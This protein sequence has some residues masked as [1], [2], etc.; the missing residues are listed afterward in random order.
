VHYLKSRSQKDEKILQLNW[1]D[2]LEL[3]LR[4]KGQG[5]SVT[6]LLKTLLY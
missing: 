4:L 2:A 3:Y 6:F 5:K 1:S